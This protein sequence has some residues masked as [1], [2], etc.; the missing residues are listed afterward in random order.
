MGPCSSCMF[1]MNNAERAEAKEGFCHRHP[2]TVFLKGD[3]YRSI[4]TP[5]RKEFGCGE[6]RPAGEGA[7][8]RRRRAVQ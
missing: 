7:P 5:V 8:R 2:P 6:F 3:E 1:F 4:F